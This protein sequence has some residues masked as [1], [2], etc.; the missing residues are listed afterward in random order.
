MA[1]T[2]SAPRR[3]MLPSV[4]FTVLLAKFG[5]DSF[6][7]TMQGDAGQGRY[8]RCA[9]CNR[10]EWWAEGGRPR[11]E[12]SPRRRH[13]PIVTEPETKPNARATDENCWF[14]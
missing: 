4:L 7:I 3:W 5:G 13:D 12:G 8:W 11:C 2:D 14:Y 6:V 1:G 10:V 9:A